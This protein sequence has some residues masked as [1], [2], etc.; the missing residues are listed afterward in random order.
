MDH[1]YLELSNL[2]SGEIICCHVGKLATIVVGLLW[3]CGKSNSCCFSLC[4]TQH[5]PRTGATTVVVTLG[6]KIWRLKTD[7]KGGGVRGRD[8]TGEEG[9]TKLMGRTYALVKI[10]K[11]KCICLFITI[12]FRR[13]NMLRQ[14][15]KESKQKETFF[16][17]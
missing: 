16:K 11:L 12:I 13:G 3:Y 6:R 17:N 2:H 1:S 5:C 4:N 15:G 7:G 9:H 14:H 8:N 10:L